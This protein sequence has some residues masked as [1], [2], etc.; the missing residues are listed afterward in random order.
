MKQLAGFGRSDHFGP[1]L[2]AGNTKHAHAK[3]A[4]FPQKVGAE[5]PGKNLV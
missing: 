2:E 1:Q 5:V 3:Q 4:E